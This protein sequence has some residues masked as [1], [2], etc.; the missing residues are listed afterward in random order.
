MTTTSARFT[1]ALAASL[2]LAAPLLAQRD[3]SMP[4]DARL[5]AFV[6]CYATRSAGIGGPMVCVVPTANAQSVELVTIANDSV[7]STVPIDASGEKV[8]RTRGDC[9]GWER[10]TFSGDERRLFVQSELT[11][12]NG[13]L[14]KMSALYAVKDNM[15]FTRVEAVQTR[16]NAGVRVVNF[17]EVGRVGVPEAIVRRM[18]PIDDMRSYAARVEAAAPITTADVA[19]VS[20]VFDGRVV[21]AWIAD[22]GQAFDLA[23][24]DLRALHDAG[25]TPDAIDM[26]IAI[27][28]PRVFSLAQGNIAMGPGQDGT[29]GAAIAGAPMTSP[30]ADP[31]VGDPYFGSSLFGYPGGYYGYNSRYG[32]Y[33]ANWFNPYAS[34][35]LAF[36]CYGSGWSY[37][38][39][40][41]IVI[42][43]QPTPA[44]AAPGSIVNG[45]GYSQGGNQGDGRRA[46]PV[47]SSIGASDFG[48]MLQ[49]GGA[50]AGGGGGGGV[51]TSTGGGGGAAS[52]GSA[53]GGEARTAKPRP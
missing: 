47:N 53:S 28:N 18:P 45:A 12:A 13:P 43:T 1:A 39:G 5:R 50:S 52:S 46:V 24:N 19:E 44:G 36:N 15:G 2:A 29:R 17:R 16:G 33:G 37:G 23:A 8:T 32:L 6:G 10:G 21:A 30:Y 34:C 40:G 42:V 26:M 7:A 49:T 22:R 48:G 35:N 9:T 14:Q 41:P 27:S 4:I 20:K 3:G 51:S 11:C 25:V 38:G 31:Y